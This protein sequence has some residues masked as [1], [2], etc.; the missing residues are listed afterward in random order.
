[1]FLWILIV[2]SITGFLTA[3]GIGA[4]DVANAFATSIGAKSL[5]KVQ[6]LIIATFCE[7]L[8]ALLMGSRVTD[9]IRKGIVD[10]ELFKDNPEVLMFGMLC[11]SI[12]TMTWLALATYFKLPVS[13]THS[14]V[15]A[16]LGFSIVYAVDTDSVGS[17]EWNKVYLIMASW[18]ISPFLSG[19]FTL[20]IFLTNKSLAFV[21][22][23]PIGRTFII[24]PIMI[25]LTVIVNIFFIIYK[26]SPQLNLDEIELWKALTI[27]FSSGIGF[28]VISYTLIYFFNARIRKYLDDKYN[29]QLGQHDLEWDNMMGVELNEPTPNGESSTDL[30]L[31]ELPREL[32]P[33]TITETA[34]T[35]LD[36]PSP[37]PQT[38]SPQTASPQTT[39]PQSASP[40]PASPQP[41]SPQSTSPSPQ[42]IENPERSMEEGGPIRQVSHPWEHDKFKH[43]Q[44]FD[45][46]IEYMYSKLQIITACLDSFAHGANDVANSIGPYAAIYTIYQEGSF[47]DKADVP[48]WILAAGGAGIV[49]GLWLWGQRIIDRVGRDLAGITPTRGFAME[50]GSSVTVIIASWFEL[51][52]STT[53]CQVGSVFAGGL[54]D[55][56]K[57]VDFK[58][59]MVI[60][61]S[62][63]ITL[64]IA[65]GLSALLFMFG[66]YS[67]KA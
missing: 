1:M 18:V 3:C 50:L 39:S 41:G 48:I 34:I 9:T 21:T 19:I 53:H 67:P 13:T 36:S 40:Q 29:Q 17:I 64:P 28:V 43:M 32:S 23:N 12:S 8:G 35:D 37:S 24:F 26:G 59:L 63:I 55:G 25:G 47:A 57:N 38:A 33:E 4:N 66:G 5:T 7:F 20:I 16:V 56:K 44:R 14:T 15:G 46:K 11:A 52:V 10:S 42:E 31:A 60:V 54:A 58:V 2:G 27:A 65:G 45:P 49:L 6:V 30:D 22:A 61:L 51:P 62:W